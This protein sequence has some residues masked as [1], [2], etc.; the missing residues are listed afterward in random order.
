[1]DNFTCL[2]NIAN[3]TSGLKSYG[4]LSLLVPIDNRVWQETSEAWHITFK[5]ISATL[6]LIYLCISMLSITFIIKKKSLRLNTRTFL[7][8]YTCIAILGLS[9][10][11]YISVDQSGIVGFISTPFPAWIVV[12]R[13]L[14]ALGFPS[15]VASC[16]LI[17]LTL[18]KLVNA[19]TEKQ[20]YEYWSYTWIIT[21]IPYAI[22]LSAES[23]GHISTYP[24][25]LAGISCEVFFVLWGLIIC[26]AYLIAGIRLLS[27]LKKSHRKATKR[28]NSIQTG[29][30]TF[31]N[32]NR[33]VRKIT[34]KIS[35]ITFGTA[36]TGVLYSMSAAGSVVM[37]LLLLFQDCMGLHARTN[38]VAWLVI[39]NFS[40]V[41]EI[42]L[43]CL[44]LY[45]IT[46]VSKILDFW[47]RFASCNKCRRTERETEI[48]AEEIEDMPVMS[49]HSEASPNHL[50]QTCVQP[51]DII[52]IDMESEVRDTALTT[53]GQS[54]SRKIFTI[55]IQRSSD[56]SI[57]S[58]GSSSRL[59]EQGGPPMSSSDSNG[60]KLLRHTE[61]SQSD[62]NVTNRY[63]DV[64]GEIFSVGSLTDQK[65]ST[66]KKKQKPERGLA[67][68]GVSAPA[69]VMAK[70]NQRHQED[71]QNQRLP[72]QTLTETNLQ[73][74]PAG[75]HTMSP[76]S[77]KSLQVPSSLYVSTAPDTKETVCRKDTV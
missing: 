11:L 37:V 41:I 63:T 31:E 9:R 25:L 28:S 49:D 66:N 64:L 24:A 62:S 44:I 46:D 59:I 45:S 35:M 30:N 15:L 65:Y 39:V 7:A 21:G 12:S 55:N 33:K 36:I 50:M 29:N 1:M 8:V 40:H 75:G 43:A 58:E 18:W 17:I 13:F 72:P 47:K 51:Q 71:D 52:A 67:S 4:T 27:Q 16:T 54:T 20:W 2:D 14:G 48:S 6:T 26:I 77:P 5:V 34:Y 32:H 42:M 74:I 68:S 22:S 76:L 56:S 38:P 23:L 53:S 57:E 73:S 3:V 61:A 69:L 19:G 60:Q 70:P 10:A